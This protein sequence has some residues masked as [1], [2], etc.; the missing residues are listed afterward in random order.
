[1][2]QSEWHRLM[3]NQE[4]VSAVCFDA[5]GTLVETKDKRSAFR[6]LLEA[7]PDCK[8][9]EFKH[10]LMREDRGR[11][12]W[13]LALRV[14]INREVLDEVSV[15]V[16]ACWQLCADAAFP[17]RFARTLQARMLHA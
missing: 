16:L 11:S 8:R 1:M 7:L 15:R 6:P 10:R 12:G 14:P 17:L 3:T 9:A 13:P 5:F 4:G 2:S